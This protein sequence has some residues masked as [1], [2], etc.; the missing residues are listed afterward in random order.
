MHYFCLCLFRFKNFGV[1]FAHCWY[2]SSSSHLQELLNTLCHL[3]HSP[4]ARCLSAVNCFSAKCN[5]LG[6]MSALKQNSA[7]LYQIVF[8]FPVSRDFI[9]VIHIDF[10]NIL[11]CFGSFSVFFLCIIFLIYICLVYCP[12]NLSLCVVLFPHTDNWF[13]NRKIKNR[14]SNWNAVSYYCSTTLPVPVM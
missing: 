12:C 13:L 9:S 7:L 3:Q 1:C 6:N 5:F 8:T 4:S 11:F 14:E 10:P 2:Y